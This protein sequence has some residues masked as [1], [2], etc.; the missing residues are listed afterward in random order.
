MDF[1]INRNQTTKELDI[2]DLFN[3]KCQFCDSKDVFTRSSYERTIQEMGT[4]SEKIT[5]FLKMR[6]FEC[7]ACNKQFTLENPKYPNKMEYSKDILEYSLTRYNYHNAS[8]NDISRDL[9]ILH[10]VDVPNNTVY[11]WLKEHS[12]NF[13]KSRLDKDPSDI[14]QNIDVLSVDGSYTTIANDII[15]KKKDVE[16]LSVTKL[17]NGQYLLMWWE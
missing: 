14:P 3:G 4:P 1:P 2:I 15:G 8:G 9:K 13:I 6:T 7:K 10:Q 16:S 17:K 5:V 12:P 11:S